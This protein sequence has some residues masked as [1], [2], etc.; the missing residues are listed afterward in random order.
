MSLIRLDVYNPLCLGLEGKVSPQGL[1]QPTSLAPQLVCVLLCQLSDFECPAIM[2][3]S[4]CHV[5][6]LRLEM[7]FFVF[8]VNLVSPACKA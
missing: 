4:K 3:T 2:C 5:A 7:V 1:L 8:Q 6:Q